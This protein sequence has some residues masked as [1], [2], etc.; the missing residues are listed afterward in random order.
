MINVEYG[1]KSYLSISDKQTG[2]REL[3]LQGVKPV[4]TD[5]TRQDCV[6]VNGRQLF[7]QPAA[8]NTAVRGILYA[9]D[10]YAC[11]VAADSSEYAYASLKTPI[12]L[13]E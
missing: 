9:G 4:L 12:R 6:D 2:N 3:F 10:G 1:F 5:V 8:L 11:W 7:P 13:S